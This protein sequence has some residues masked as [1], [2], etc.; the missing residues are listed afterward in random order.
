[1]TYSRTTWLIL[2]LS[3]VLTPLFA[4]ETDVNYDKIELGGIMGWGSPLG[5]GI[6]GG[7]YFNPHSVATAGLGFGFSGFKAG[8]G[9]KYLLNP[10]KMFTPF[11]GIYLSSSSGLSNL[12][13][14]VNMDSAVYRI[15]PASL[16][17]LRTGLRFQV[18]FIR[19]Y[20]HLG[21]GIA[22]NGGKSHYESG[23]LSED[24]SDFARFM[25]PGG[26]EISIGAGLR[27]PG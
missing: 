8:A 19:V 2:S 21:Y 24:V 22:L 25:E 9:V 13:V 17:S 7:Y 18:G 10:D 27:I 3:L 15:D 4:H 6:E 11:G 12:N 26:I 20:G 1:M 5:V 23:S 14:T 16:L